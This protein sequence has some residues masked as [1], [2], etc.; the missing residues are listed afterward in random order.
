MKN[1]KLSVKLI[2]GF[3]I[4][5]VIT[6]MV[7]IVGWRGAVSLDQR[8][9]EVGVVRLPS[10]E[11]LLRMQES[12]M[13]VQERVSILLSPNISL[14]KRLQQH[15]LILE[16]RGN[17]Q[18]AWDIFE[19][20]PRTSE[21]DLLWT[22]FVPAY[23]KVREANDQVVKMSEE[24]V[25]TGIL[26][27][28]LLLSNLNQFR[29][30]HYE[31]MLNV[32]DLI[33]FNMDFEGG[34]DHHACAF[35]RWMKETVTENPEL[36]DMIR[37]M[38]APH[39]AFH[40]YV[41]R[42]RTL[43]AA[44]EQENARTLLKT[45]MQPR[46]DEVFARFDEMIHVAV[47]ANDNFYQMVEFA[48]EDAA[49]EVSLGMKL[50]D[51]IIGV[52]S[53]IAA[54]EVS[55]AEAEAAQVKLMVMLGMV[56]G[57]LIAIALGI[58]LTMNI[59]RP[60]LK[61]VDFARVMAGGDLT[62]KLD[63]TQKD[64]VGQLA[65]AL[66]I[67][68]D[69]LRK[70]IRDIL[71]VSSYLGSSS[72]EIAA[73]ISQVTSGAQETATSVMETT[74]TV[75]EVNQTSEATSNKAKEVAENARQGLQTAESTRQSMEELAG[76]MNLT[77]EQM[78]RI[79]ETIIKLSEQSQAIGE[80]TATVDDIA[81]QTNLLAVNA[82]IEAARAGEQGKGFTVVAREIKGLAE[83]SKQATRQ[84]RTILG[85][86]QKA[87]GAAVMAM[88]KGSKSVDQGLR[89]VDKT[90]RSMNVL[91]KSFA[92]SAQSAAQIAAASREQFTGMD[93]V[94]QAMENI[95]EASEQNVESMKQLESSAHKLREL[96]HKL[97]E[98]MEQ[99][100]L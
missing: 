70:K 64:E 98:L 94:N 26:N 83:Q 90:S 14:E 59:T 18:K 51:R 56:I 49:Q 2:C 32:R 19:P 95:R 77:N 31:V 54:H 48:L 4:V 78:S 53:E 67:M 62:G 74:A 5:A 45:E 21:E 65:D 24:V 27:P 57:T 29:G 20:L 28:Y 34:D 15:E 84:V 81:E 97:K 93:Q 7:G 71:E 61:G 87:T 82:S 80:I 10:V 36:S 25:S 96:G 3:L 75:Q 85:D 22:R 33:D 60:I 72:E 69:S 30:D 17:L 42:I 41:P 35:G 55:L 52:N 12:I 89:D 86:I 63:I 68:V 92:D 58:F 13:E 43:V 88:E 44:G 73:S 6:L 47:Q 40:G 99:Y 9:H 50:L 91:N 1:I 8:I 38:E 16:A 100:K 37:G 79:S 23:E 39:N 46:A 11:S 76:G 66:N